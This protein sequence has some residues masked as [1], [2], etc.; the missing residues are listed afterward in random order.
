MELKTFE[1]TIEQHTTFRLLLRAQSEEHVRQMWKESGLAP[2]AITTDQK[3]ELVQVREIKM[4]PALR[5]R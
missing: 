4:S 2:S 3:Q 1:V 5:T